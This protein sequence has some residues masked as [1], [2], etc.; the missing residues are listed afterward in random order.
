MAPLIVVQGA[1]A[2]SGLALSGFPSVAPTQPTV[3]LQSE[4]TDY[5][6]LFRRPNP[7]VHELQTTLR[8]AYPLFD[9]VTFELVG[10]HDH[11]WEFAA[12][13]K[14]YEDGQWHGALRITGVPLATEHFRLG[15]WVGGGSWL[16]GGISLW[17][18]GDTTDFVLSHGITANIWFPGVQAPQS[19]SEVGEDRVTTT[20]DP[21]ASLPEAMLEQHI[22]R[23]HRFRLGVL[24]MI[25]VLGYGVVTEHVSVR[26]AVGSIGIRHHAFLAVAGHL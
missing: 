15:L 18:G 25:P 6:G 8:V 19:W 7:Q 21:W 12:S 20:L 2:S 14:S 26:L 17:A 5:R 4:L 9:R 16:E 11:V 10:R 1:L 13:Q 24:G 23:W 22:A 3:Q